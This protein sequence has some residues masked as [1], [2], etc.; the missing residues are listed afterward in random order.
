MIKVLG[1]TSLILFIAL[2]SLSAFTWKLHEKY[3]TE[4]NNAETYL[5]AKQEFERKVEKANETSKEYQKQLSIVDREL[6]DLRMQYKPHDCVNVNQAKRGLDGERAGNIIFDGN[7]ERGLSPDW[8]FDFAG[9]C[10]KTRQKVIGL[11]NFYLNQ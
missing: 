8:L 10:E 9:R 5:L 2:G 3:V 1:I 7:E 4:K 11:Q 6:S